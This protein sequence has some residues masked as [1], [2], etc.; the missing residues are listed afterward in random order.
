MRQNLDQILAQP[1]RTFDQACKDTGYNPTMFNCCKGWRKPDPDTYAAFEIRPCY[2]DNGY[3]Q[4]CEHEPW[5]AQ[6]WTVYGARDREWTE[7][8][9]ITDVSTKKLAWQILLKLYF[10]RNYIWRK[11]A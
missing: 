1:M 6:F 2:D 5:L 10:S 11:S 8:E 3:T 4:S 7:W 9:A